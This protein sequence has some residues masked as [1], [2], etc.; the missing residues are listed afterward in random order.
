MHEIGVMM[1]VVK[2]VE[3]FAKQNGVTQIQT[4]VLQIGELSSVIPRY[5]EACFPAAADGTILQDTKL[6]IEIL[7]GNALCCECSKVFNIMENKSKCPY[8]DCR[9]WEMLSGKEFNIKEI[10][11]C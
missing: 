5:I 11:A 1:E 3:N 9:D 4:L 7:P 8:C 2:T 10:V 6:E